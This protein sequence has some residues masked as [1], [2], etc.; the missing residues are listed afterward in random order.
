M[1]RDSDGDFRKYGFNT[2]QC[3]SIRFEVHFV[4]YGRLAIFDGVMIVCA[5]HIHTS[6]YY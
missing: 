4:Q 6:G 5:T 1:L 2:I 3:D